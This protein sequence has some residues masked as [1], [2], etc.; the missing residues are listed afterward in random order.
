MDPIAFNIF[1]LPV[2]WYG[3]LMSS[4][5]LIGLLLAMH[6]A[7]KN[8]YDAEKILDLV[9]YA[10]P[11]AIIGARLYYVIFKWEYYSQY[12]KEIFAIWHGGLAIH[13][14][15]IAA[16]IVAIIYTRKKGLSFWEIVDYMAPSLILGQAIGRWGNFFNQEAY[17]GETNLP[18]A[19]TVNDP[20]KGMIKVHP[21]FFYEFL[22]NLA[23][24]FFLLWYGKRK[25]ANGEV[26]LLYAILY[27]VGRFFIEGLRTDSL[28]FGEIRVAQLIS[29]LTIIMGVVIINYLRKNRTS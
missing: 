21:T 14:A 2:R 10:T 25:K 17:G 7:K 1:G 18:W 16:I 6:L 9:F 20:I 3:L 12:P 13:G 29:V 26:F 28:M 4:S 5:I 22:W 15:V 27:S 24:F 11:A 23:I 8:N 19:I